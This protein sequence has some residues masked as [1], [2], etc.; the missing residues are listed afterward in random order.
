MYDFSVFTPVKIN[1]IKDYKRLR[2]TKAYIRHRSSGIESTEELMKK[3]GYANLNKFKKHR[4]EF[5]NLERNIPL[6]YLDAIGVNYATLKF[7]GELD[8]EEFDIARGIE[9]L[10]PQFAMVRLMTT[11]YSNIEFP[12]GTTEK[13]AIEYLINYS[14]ETGKKCVINYRDFKTVTVDPEGRV[15]IVYHPPSFRITKSYLIPGETGNDIGKV[16]I[17]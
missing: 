11:I 17:R 15:K 7:C 6:A 3:S 5:E 4:K 12:E 14:A 10:H 13:Q 8:Q 1:S 9:D 2:N 16:E